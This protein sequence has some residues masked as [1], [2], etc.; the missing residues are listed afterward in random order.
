MTLRREPR[1][2]A[3]CGRRAQTAK[4]KEKAK[5]EKATETAAKEKATDQAK[6]TNAAKRPRTESSPKKR[7]RAAAAKAEEPTVAEMQAELRRLKLPTGGSKQ[8]LQTRLRGLGAEQLLDFREQTMA[9]R[10]ENDMVNRS[11][12]KPEPDESMRDGAGGTGNRASSVWW[13]AEEDNMIRELV[14]QNGARK[15]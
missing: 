8:E 14:G 7:A 12:S 13:T 4:A 11:N 9:A 2:R 15:W 1:L 5:K 3:P 10:A 6:R